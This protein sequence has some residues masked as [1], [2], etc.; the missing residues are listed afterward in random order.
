MQRCDTVDDYIAQADRWR[1]EL[2]RLR[3]ILVA[4]GLEECIKWGAPCYTYAGRNVVGMAGFKSYFGLWFHQGALLADD[5]KVLI[6]AQEGKTRS[7]RQWRMQSGADIRPTI[8][9][10]YVREAV[11]LAREGRNV[12]PVKPK[13]TVLPEELRAALAKDSATRKRF[14]EL[15]P[16]RQR[17]YAEYIASAKRAATRASRLARILPMIAA[18][19]GLNDRYR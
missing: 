9:R 14:D 16:G 8:I 6:N 4:T 3:E 2:T 17:D 11:G 18:G 5:A 12:T 13:R 7:L 19:I 15:T 1:A 10:R